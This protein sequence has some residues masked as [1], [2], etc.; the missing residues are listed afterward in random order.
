MTVNRHFLKGQVDAHKHR[1]I[2]NVFV[3]HLKTQIIYHRQLVQKF[4]DDSGM[5]CD[6]NG[7]VLRS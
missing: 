5:S 1:V 3:Q 2:L 7:E 6:G 4:C